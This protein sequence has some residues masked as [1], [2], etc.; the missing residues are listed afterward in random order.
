MT[1]WSGSANYGE[2]EISSGAD[3]KAVSNEIIAG[4]S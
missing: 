1:D 4:T 3:T 2:S